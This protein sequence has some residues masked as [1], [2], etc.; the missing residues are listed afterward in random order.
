MQRMRDGCG[1]IGMF[2]G[3]DADAMKDWGQKERGA[4]EDE[5]LE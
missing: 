4:A 3:K 2:I 1:F 5:M